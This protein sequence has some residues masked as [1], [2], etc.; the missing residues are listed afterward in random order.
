MAQEQ[1][2]DAHETAADLGPGSPAGRD[3]RAA[4]RWIRLGLVFLLLWSA[5]WRV[6]FAS[7]ELN[8]GRF[9]DER[10]AVNN[11][12]VALESGS[13]TPRSY[14]Y[15]S[16]SY[17]PQLALLALVERGVRLVG[18]G[19]YSLFTDDDDLK[20]EGYL[21]CRLT[22]VAFA[23]LSLW[24]T[25]DIG[26][27]L[28][29]PAVGLVAV[30]LLATSPIH[31][32][33]SAYFKPD[34]LVLALALLSTRW[35]LATIR[36]PRW[37][38]YL[39]AGAG[40]GL[41]ASA[42]LTGAGCAIMLVTSVL[43]LGGRKRWLRL[44]GAGIAAIAVFTMLN[45]QLAS[46]L[47]AFNRNLDLY[48]EKK[49][50]LEAG[51]NT[52]REINS[53]SLDLDGHLVA[54]LIAATLAA[55]AALAW[56]QWRRRLPGAA[57][58]L[59]GTITI[60]SYPA[61]SVLIYAA[62]TTYPKA[63]NFLPTLGAVALAFSWLLASLWRLACRR[64]P[65]RFRQLA[66]AAPVLAL[67]LATIYP[68]Q[69]YVYLLMTRTTWQRAVDMLAFAIPAVAGRQVYLEDPYEGLAHSPASRRIDEA[70]PALDGVSPD[71]LANSDAEVFATDQMRGP[72]RAF[73]HQRAAQRPGVQV[74]FID[75]QLF[76]TRGEPL[77]VVLHPARQVFVHKI[78][79]VV[80]SADKGIM[81]LPPPPEAAGCRSF[82]IEIR[83]PTSGKPPDLTL[84]RAG[85]EVDLDYSHEGGWDVWYSDRFAGAGGRLPTLRV[86]KAH[87]H[88]AFEA[89]LYCWEPLL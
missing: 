14:Y 88:D 19:D 43:L 12:Q 42:K 78:L 41:A 72:R 77:V 55:A 1:V 17:L 66:A 36:D 62:F 79:P 29:S 35:A 71:D 75:P 50:H 24:L 8:D 30:L 68:A 7:T 54:I 13:L 9:P 80:A 25:Y 21:L 64:V 6:W 32:R 22:V 20:P 84:A 26:K 23:L 76:F 65:P 69:Q 37:P 5:A 51:W 16:L 10:Y 82:S 86:K 49:R 58:T 89:Q 2:T 46:Y 87:L 18:A 52:L 38:R 11:I 15:Q 70:V 61:A 28:Y 47:R 34:M 31:I 39:L 56:W 27:R 53:S 44:G 3:R 33:L 73:Y 60:V 40:V 74:Q 85:Q 4:P 83:A 81:V 57:D 67:A 63:N 48:A 59:Y 45:P